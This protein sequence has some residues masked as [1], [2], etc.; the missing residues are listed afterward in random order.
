[1]IRL[2]EL[3][4]REVEGLNR[5]AIEDVHRKDPACKQQHRLVRAGDLSGCLAGIFYQSQAGYMHLP[6]ER[7][8]GLLLYRIAEGQF[9]M[10][11]N[12]RTAIFAAWF[13]LAN[14]GYSLYMDENRLNKRPNHRSC[15][16]F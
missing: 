13:F 9:F 2:I 8:A 12:K 10:D 1:M 3:Q 11:G 14:N 5:R 7:M 16:I 15:E 6:I 4:S